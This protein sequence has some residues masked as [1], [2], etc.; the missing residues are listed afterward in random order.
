MSGT[1]FLSKVSDMY[2]DTIR[3]VLSGATDL[4]SVTDTI[5]HAAIHKIITAPWHEES[6]IKKI[7]AAFRLYQQQL[8]RK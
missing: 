3:L 5:N 2:P 1:E 4:H 7:K 6:F 8:K